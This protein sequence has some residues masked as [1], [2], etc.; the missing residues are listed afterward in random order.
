MEAQDTLSKDVKILR[1]NIFLFL[2]ECD[3]SKYQLFLQIASK[4]DISI[5]W[6]LFNNP[7]I[8]RGSSLG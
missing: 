6:E 2:V 4:C 7:Q 5:V 1:R 8:I 3:L